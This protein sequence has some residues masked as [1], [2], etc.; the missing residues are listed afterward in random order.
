[1]ARYA[2]EPFDY[3][4]PPELAGGQHPN[5][6]PVAIIGAGPIGLSMA[7]DLA[8]KDIR[9]VVLDDNN[10]VSVGSR[11][12][13]W[14]KRTLEIFDRLG[15][16]K[17]MLDKGVTWKVGRLY[18]GSEEVYSF[19]LLPEEGHT[20]PAF[21]NLQQYYVEQYLVERAQEFPDLID[22][23]FGNRVTDHSDHGD[24][25]S[26]A[27]ETP[28]GDYTLNAEYMIACD[29]ARSPTR[30]RMNLPFEGHT[31]EEKFLIVDVEME[32]S[33]FTNSGR[34]RSCRAMVLVR[35]GF[36]PR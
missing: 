34:I 5:R 3:V 11:A 6:Y 17:R 22:L 8:L 2:Y 25:V 26:L 20:Y 30:Q 19:D 13:C 35:T 21:I 15:V 4:T 27:V 7:I 32:E 33:P 24:H 1:M 14:A 10:V 18:H 12:I 29:G 28:D 16:G 9:S 36:S 23:R 31:F